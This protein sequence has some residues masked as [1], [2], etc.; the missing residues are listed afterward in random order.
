LLTKG[1]IA[2]SGVYMGKPGDVPVFNNIG[3]HLSNLD[4]ASHDYRIRASQLIVNS[5]SK[6]LETDSLR[7]ISQD[8]QQCDI[9]IPSLKM[10]GF[11]VMKLMNEKILIAKKLAIDKSKISISQNERSA[12]ATFPLT[13]KKIHIDDLHCNTSSVSY[14]DKTNEFNFI[15][16]IELKELDIDSSLKIAG[17]HIG[18]VYGNIS[19]LHYSGINY[20]TAE[21]RNIEIDSKKELIQINEVHITPHVAKYE[22]RKSSPG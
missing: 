20:H 19:G 8:Q 15:A 11:D 21:I 22:A 4:Y 16:N 9:M 14:K 6:T 5:N 1:D 3:V 7:I 18:S 13:L 10:T 12:G 2:L 17:S